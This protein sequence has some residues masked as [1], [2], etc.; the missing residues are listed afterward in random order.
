MDQSNPKNYL[1]AEQEFFSRVESCFNESTGTF[2]E[3]LHAFTR[4]V[5]RQSIS[6]FLARS[7]IFNQILDIHGSIL[8][9]GVYRGSS[10]FTWQQL[11]SILEPFNHVRRVVGFDSFKG[12]SEISDDDTSAIQHDLK[13]KVEGGMAFDGYEEIQKGIE[14]LDLNR[15]LGHIPKGTCVTG[16]LPDSL[17]GYLREHPETIVSLANFGLGLYEPTRTILEL[18]KPRL[19]KGSVIVFEDLNQS[20]WP[21]ETKAFLEVF[22]PHSVTLNRLPYCPHISWI[23]IGR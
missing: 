8:D 23:T 15:P 17:R 19:V 11:S 10:F 5:P 16:I 2:T 12:F 13:L 4:F 18:I 1:T 9:F 3:K 14:L 20:T 21:G 22:E 7:T 6:H